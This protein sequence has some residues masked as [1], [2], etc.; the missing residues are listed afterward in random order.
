MIL[1]AVSAAGCGTDLGECKEPWDVSSTNAAY[2]YLG[3]T[4]G[5]GQQ[6]RNE[7]TWPGQDAVNVTCAGGRCHSALASG[8]AREGAPAGLDFDAP[9][10]G[11]SQDVVPLAAQGIANIRENAD[12]IWEEVDDGTM[13]P[14]GANPDRESVRNWL[15]CGAPAN[16]PRV[17]IP[18]GADYSS[19][20]AGLANA[21]MA[22][23]TEAVKASFGNFSI[24]ADVC[25]SYA[26]IVNQP[27][28]STA[29]AG[30]T[31]VVPGD[32]DNSFM[33]QKMT[34]TPQCGAPMPLNGM[35]PLE[36]SNPATFNAMRDWILAG[37]PKPDVCP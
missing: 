22:C 31:L 30:R 15:A 11:T 17:E 26:L 36:T 29:C 19:V 24:G 14:S 4:N 25:E 13:P 7:W 18:T 20:Y 23:H 6:Q 28:T 33:L 21:C 8:K 2:V 37:A 5:D 32:P 12:S 27:S 35:P 9:L 16:A 34:G 10:M 3:D 1:A